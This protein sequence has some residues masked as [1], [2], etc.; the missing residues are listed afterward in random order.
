MLNFFAK[1]SAFGAGVFVGVCYGSI[2]ATF[3]SFAVM[4]TIVG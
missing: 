1:M 4:S 3:T 2:V